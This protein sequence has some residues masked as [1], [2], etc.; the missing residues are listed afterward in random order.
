MY[1]DAMWQVTLRSCAM[2]YLYEEL[3]VLVCTDASA[4]TGDVE[5]PAA[6]KQ[7][8]APEYLERRRTRRRSNGFI[9]GTIKL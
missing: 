7:H 4:V 9:T 6:R 1:T 5:E 8:E 2:G 3:D